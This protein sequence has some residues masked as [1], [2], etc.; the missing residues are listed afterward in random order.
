MVGDS[1]SLG[2]RLV[3]LCSCEA[4]IDNAVGVDVSQ[5]DGLIGELAPPEPMGRLCHARPS[6]H[7]SRERPDLTVHARGSDCGERIEVPV[8]CLD[9]YRNPPKPSQV[10][11]DQLKDHDSHGS[12]SVGVTSVG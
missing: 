4:N 6:G 1:Q 8:K 9:Q 12:H 3:M 7:L 11:N 2:K 10:V 5:L